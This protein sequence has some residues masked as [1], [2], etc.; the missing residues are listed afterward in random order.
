VAEPPVTFASLLR[1]LR[2]E[3]Q[4]TQEELAEASGVRPR[5]ISDLERGVAVTPQRDTIRRLADALNLAGLVRAQFDA[6]A[7]GREAPAA[8]EAAGTS[9]AA[10]TRTLPRD[11]ASFTGRQ[12]ELQELVTA[13]AGAAQSGGVVSIHAIGGMAGIGKTATGAGY[14]FRTRQNPRTA[15]SIWDAV[16]ARGGPG[17]LASLHGREHERSPTGRGT[18]GDHD[19]TPDMTMPRRDGRGTDQTATTHA[20]AYVDTP[21]S[22]VYV[23]SLPLARYNFS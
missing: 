6:V 7:R 15:V 17:D 23:P 16:D 5:S 8:T 19:P 21:A 11:I 13:T 10:A 1:K 14:F 20:L 22:P 18:A 3:A 2:T 4:L 12:Q 9:V